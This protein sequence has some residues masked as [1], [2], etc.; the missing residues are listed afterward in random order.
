MSHPIADAIKSRISTRA[1]LDKQVPEEEIRAVLDVARWSPSGGNLQPWRVHVL[2]GAARDRLVETVKKA[3]ADNPFAD[4]AELAVYPSGLV[5]PYRTR[6]YEVGEA[7]YERLGI[8]REDKTAR[9]LHLTRNFEFFDAPVGLFFSLDRMF[10]KGQWAHLGMF[11][12]TLALAAHERGLA[13][14]MQEAWVTRAKTVS[15]F[16]GLA[17]N[18]QL[19]CGMAMGYA[20]PAAPVNDLRSARAHIDD[21]TTFL[22]N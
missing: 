11:M 14:C 18:E 2:T 7:M 9:L 8:P 10:D 20:D 17:E 22:S 6:R 1:F 3:I 19:Y 4:E 13:T 15:A 21:F 5:E 16:L 12:Q